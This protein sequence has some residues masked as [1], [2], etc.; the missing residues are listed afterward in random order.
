MEIDYWG[1]KMWTELHCETLATNT[2]PWRAGPQGRTWPISKGLMAP[3]E[4]RTPLLKPAKM[5]LSLI[6]S[7]LHQRNAWTR[8]RWSQRPM[9]LPLSDFHAGLVKQWRRKGDCISIFILITEKFSFIIHRYSGCLGC[10]IKKDVIFFFF[11]TSLWPQERETSQMWYKN[12]L[13]PK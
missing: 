2:S 9:G 6:P 10:L 5:P 13:L 12:K 7:D 1:N 8:W 4:E 11:F 3:L